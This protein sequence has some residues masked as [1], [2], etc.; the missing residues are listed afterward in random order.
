MT[1]AKT[2][3][4]MLALLVAGAA[5]LSTN[6]FETVADDSVF[7]ATINDT[8]AVTA[9]D[10]SDPAADLE[11]LMHREHEGGRH[12]PWASAIAGPVIVVGL[13]VL[14]AVASAKRSRKALKVHTVLKAIF[15]IALIVL[16]VTGSGG[17]GGRRDRDG[18]RNDNR[19]DNDWEEGEDRGPRD[20]H[21]GGQHGHHG[22]RT[23]PLGPNANG[24]TASDD[25]VSSESSLASDNGNADAGH[26][27]GDMS[28][29]L[30]VEHGWL[31][32]ALRATTA[33]LVLV[34]FVLDLVM[35]VIAVQII[36]LTRQGVDTAAATATTKETPKLAFDSSSSSGFG[37]NMTATTNASYAG[38][39]Q[40]SSMSGTTVSASAPL[41]SS[42]LS[43]STSGENST[44][45]E[46]V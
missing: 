21:G 6:P 24:T 38:D 27:E 36:A 42:S 10:G 46:S 33:G 31:T 39:D 43:S 37:G 26:H 32:I 44:S 1:A 17:R 30:L 40:A 41:P 34:A 7:I 22:P 25:G 11:V 2:G 23:D 29:G 9:D 28:N 3:L 19:N 18:N 20:P 5:W 14:G 13:L 8:T 45:A 15:Y 4:L 16:I 12:F 35:T